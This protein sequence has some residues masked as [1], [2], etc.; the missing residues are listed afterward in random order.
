M[1]ALL[2]GATLAPTDPATL[3]PI[4]RQVKI[5]IGSRRLLMSEFGV[6]RRHRRDRYLRCFVDRY[7]TTRIFA[8]VV[9]GGLLK[10][11]ILGIVAGCVSAISPRCSS[12]TAIEAFLS[13]YGPVVTLRAVIG[14]YFAADGLQV[15]RFMAVFVFGIMLG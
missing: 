11:S 8:D 9:A 4:F 2:L 7:G 10:Q 14:A 13:E 5:A 12:P 3:V 1:V 15:E 6:Q